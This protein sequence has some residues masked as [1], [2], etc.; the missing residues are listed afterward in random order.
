MWRRLVAGLLVLFMVTVV[1]FV[2]G[3]AAYPPIGAAGVVMIGRGPDCPASEALRA[4]RRSYTAGLRQAQHAK[5]TLLDKTDGA[6]QH[7]QTPEGSFW[8]PRMQG[9]VITS[10][11]SELDGKYSDFAP[12]PI[13]AGDVVLD[14]G[15]NVG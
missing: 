10:Q 3:F 12:A 9:S 5:T 2:V 6:Y 11:L 13:Q 14:C 7:V 1:A 4:Y 15:A 8:E